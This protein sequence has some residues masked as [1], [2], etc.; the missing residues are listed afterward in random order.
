MISK[1]L[2]TASESSKWKELGSRDQACYV[3]FHIL[4]SIENLSNDFNINYLVPLVNILELVIYA[5][6]IIL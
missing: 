3:V 2:E 4:H 1:M 5:Y 6:M